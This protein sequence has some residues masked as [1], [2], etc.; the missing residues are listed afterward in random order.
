MTELGRQPF[1]RVVMAA[2]ALSLSDCAADG[3]FSRA[4]ICEA[5]G[6]T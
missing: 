4:A 5:A 3:R 1:V 6:G 2:L